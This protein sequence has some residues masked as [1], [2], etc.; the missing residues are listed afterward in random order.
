MTTVR[1]ALVLANRSG[2]DRLDA[3][4]LLAHVMQQDR[5]WLIAHDDAIL[6]PGQST[7]FADLAARCAHGEPMGYLLGEQAFHGLRLT[8]TP[9][10]LIPRPDTETLVDW[11]LEHVAEGTSPEV[12]DLGTGSGAIALA[13]KHRRPQARLAG[14]DLSPDALAVARRNAAMHHLAVDW[15]L[16]TWFEPVAS[17][18]FALIVSNPPYIAGHDAH[19]SALQHEPA[20]ALT[21]GGDGLDAIR[22]IVA[23]APRHLLDG[24]WLLLEHGYDQAAP[25]AKLLWEHGFQHVTSRRDLAGRDRCTGAQWQFRG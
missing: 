11:A 10:V 7:A 6:S 5:G 9:A 19:L 14:V 18:R 13:I 25:V 20:M 15:M 3:Q 16:G 22:H 1:E 23:Q 4:R 24:A 12:L 8:V 21:P 2:L 17:R